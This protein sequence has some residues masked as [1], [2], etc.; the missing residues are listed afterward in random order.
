MHHEICSAP[1]PDEFVARLR[2]EWAARPPATMDEWVKTG[3]RMFAQWLA[4]QEAVVDA[5]RGTGDAHAP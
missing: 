3:K 5:P 2:A 1:L 4:E